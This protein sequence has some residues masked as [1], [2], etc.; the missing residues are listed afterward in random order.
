M[1]LRQLQY[2]VQI[3]EKGSVR[4]AASRVRVAQSALSRHVRALEDELGIALFDRHAR[5]VTLTPAGERLRERAA[6]IL[7]RVEDARAA[8]MAE[9]AFLSG[10]VAIGCSGG[11]SRLLY[12]RLAERA[13]RDCPGIVLQLVEGAPY[14]LLEGLDTGRLDL[15]IMVNPDSRPSLDLEPLATEQVYLIGS[16]DSLPL[17]DASRGVPALAGLPLVL[18]PR[19]SGSRMYFERA[20]A[21]AQITL[22]IAYEVDSQDVQKEFVMRGLGHGL[23]PYS[24]VHREMREGRIA[25]APL[26]GLSLARTLVQRTDHPL[27]PAASELSRLVREETAAL[28]AEGVFG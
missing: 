28:A 3:A 20:A 23:L 9:G 25:G 5:G 18:F 17:P 10:K 15:A 19:P 6:D 2:F 13:R 7:H 12:G 24:S 21:E 14:L 4:E 26:A 11:T 27:T 1:D 8:L 22:D 16:P